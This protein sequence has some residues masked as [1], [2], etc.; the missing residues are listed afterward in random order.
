MHPEKSVSYSFQ[1]LKRDK[2]PIWMETTGRNMLDNP[3]VKGIIFNTRD[4]TIQRMADKERMMKSQMQSLSENSPD[5]IIRFGVDGMLHYVNPKV[6]EYLGFSQK[7][8]QGKL[9]DDTELKKDIKDLFNDRTSITIS[10]NIKL[11]TEY[12]ITIGQKKVCLKISTIPEYNVDNE[13][14]S[15]LLVA[16]DLTEIK[17]IEREIKEKNL[18]LNDSIN[19]AQRIQTAILPTNETL[20]NYFNDSFIFYKARDVVSGDY[21][22]FKANTDGIYV[23]AVDCTGHGVP[24]ALLSFIGYFLLNNIV[25]SNPNDDSAKLLNKFD[26]EVKM[27]LKQKDGR[28]S[29]HDGMDI[30]LCKFSNDLKHLSFAGAHRPLYIMRGDKLLSF[31]GDRRPIGGIRHRTKELSDFTNHSIDLIK[32]DRIFI[33]SDGLSDQFKEGSLEKFQE[34][35]VRQIIQESHDLSMAN[36]HNLFEQRLSK[37]QGSYR[38]IDDMLLI[39][40]EI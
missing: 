19:Y 29:T 11:E 9:L 16:H 23:A 15:I 8:L 39:G 25:N 26:A 33:F 38:Q 10:K 28:Q 27:T 34:K 6:K 13:I 36:I 40:I 20:K 31:K 7:Q 35:Q 17:A 22:W 4:I 3:A 5:L 14:D 18:K 30:G 32:G 37:W 24:G 1:I 21:P 2:T 12:E